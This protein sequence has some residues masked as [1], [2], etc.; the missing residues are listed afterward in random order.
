MN[1]LCLSQ[2]NANLSKKEIIK[3]VFRDIFNL[4]LSLLTHSHPG[5]VQLRFS[6]TIT[7]VLQRLYI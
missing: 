3:N 1:L 6:A 4:S 5:V 2:T 7:I